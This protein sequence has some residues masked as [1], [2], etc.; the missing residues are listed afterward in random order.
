MICKL[1]GITPEEKQ[2]KYK[3]VEIY[4]H[5]WQDPGALQQIGI[6]PRDKVYEFSN[7][8]LNQ[9]VPI[10]INKLI[11]NYDVLC[12]VGPVFPH[13]VVGFSGGNNIFLSRNF[14]S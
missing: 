5:A 12:I 9:E 14:R 10:Q 6:I 8:L 3:D 2:S 1:V 11:F 4:N 7:G 13:E